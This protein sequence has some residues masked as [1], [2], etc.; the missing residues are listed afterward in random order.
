VKV[1]STIV[2]YKWQWRYV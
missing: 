1:D 2:C